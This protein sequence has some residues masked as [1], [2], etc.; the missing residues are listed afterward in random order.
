MAFQKKKYSKQIELNKKI[1]KV[2]PINPVTKR[3]D[4][5]KRIKGKAQV[6]IEIKKQ[7]EEEGISNQ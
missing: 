2:F 6:K 1:R 4:S 7:I 3:I 5:K